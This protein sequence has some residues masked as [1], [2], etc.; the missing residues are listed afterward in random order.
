MKGRGSL[1][2]GIHLDLKYLMPR[3]SYLLRWVREIAA[4]GI[5]TL[6]LEYEDK[7]PFQKYSFLSVS[8][9]FTAS[10]L[11]TFLDAARSAGLRVVPLVQTLSHL[12]F[13]LAHE[14]LARLREAPD[15]PTQICPLN[16]EA[17]RFVCELI[18]EVL[19]YHEQDEWFHLGADEAWFLG[20]CPR[21]SAA[22]VKADRTGLW[23]QHVGALA[24]KLLDA[25]KRPLV[26]DDIYWRESER[27]RRSALPRETVL[28]S[29]DYSCTS[30]DPGAPA[31]RTGVYREAGFDVLGAPCHNWGVLV[32]MHDHCLRNTAA[33]AARVRHERLLGLLNTSWAC[34]HT[35]LPT[36]LP[37]VAATAALLAGETRA[38]EDSW[39]ADWFGRYFGAAADTLPG[40]LRDLCTNWEVR[41]TG[42]GRPI[43]PIVYG[44]M[45]LVLHFE[46]GQDERRKR[47]VYPLDWS[48]VDF[49]GLYRR[50]VELL[51]G[52]G[53]RQAVR[54]KLAELR[55]TYE[56]AER[57]LAAFAGA[58]TRNRDHARFLVLSAEMKRLHAC[59]LLHLLFGDGD[60][61]ALCEEHRALRARLVECLT[62]FF[63]DA[64]VRRLLDLWWAPAAAAL[65]D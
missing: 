16:T 2:V 27:T 55:S 8:E 11:R 49:P 14:E 48:E 23:E 56:R 44:Y 43:T 58:V 40:A 5:D 1:I 22:L 29:W 12:E 15:I 64:S 63:E 37:Y 60:R 65:K 62:P 24:R 9:A 41:I 26:W 59:T 50:K 25:G 54:A 35:P 31:G 36:Q 4:L 7:F 10:E 20:T 34:F 3:K 21:C 28:V 46:G 47:G 32:P 45:D 61:R 17:V 38:V 42:L 6:L 18:D 19:A 33:W 39:Q 57:E 13:A 53:D 52:L 51:R 30:F